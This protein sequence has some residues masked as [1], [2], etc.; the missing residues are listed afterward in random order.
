VIDKREL[1]VDVAF[2]VFLENPD[3]QLIKL[4]S[5]KFLGLKLLSLLNKLPCLEFECLIGF[6]S[7]VLDSIVG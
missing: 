6:N 1:A 3:R 7:Q 5:V 4:A 2:L